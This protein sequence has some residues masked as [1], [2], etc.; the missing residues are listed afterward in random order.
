MIMSGSVGRREILE[1]VLS[2]RFK[3]LCMLSFVSS[4]RGGGSCSRSRGFQGG[5]QALADCKGWYS[6]GKGAGV[7]GDNGI[8]LVQDVEGGASF[9]I[10]DSVNGSP[11]D[12]V[13][14]P[15]GGSLVGQSGS[16]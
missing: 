12:P 2:S 14:K 10:G 3:L 5:C 16:S 7:G 13:D 4:S 8:S 11:G 1:V 9:L 15:A 6:V